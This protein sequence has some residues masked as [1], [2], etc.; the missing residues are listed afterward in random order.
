MFA[1]VN[2]ASRA[3]GEALSLLIKRR[4]TTSLGFESSHDL[5][6]E[7]QSERSPASR[8]SQ[9]VWQRCHAPLDWCTCA[10]SNR[11][12]ASNWTVLL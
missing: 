3:E 12:P 5:M 6:E 4:V 2:S 1:V 9:L 10:D 8:R 11:T 7:S